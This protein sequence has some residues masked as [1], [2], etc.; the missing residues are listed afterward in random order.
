M[1]QIAANLLL[2]PV[3]L[4]AKASGPPATATGAIAPSGRSDTRRAVALTFDDLPATAVVGGNC[5]DAKL[6]ALNRR[7]LAHL[8]RFEIRA[9]GLVTETR[10]CAEL[11]E[12]VLPRAL[13]L[14]LDDGHDLGNHTYS[15]PDLNATPLDEY[16]RDV[17]RGERIVRRLLE[18]RGR[19]LRG[20]VCGGGRTRDP[21]GSPSAF[22]RAQC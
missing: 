6:I 4:L 20:V 14:W 11:R 5:D 10:V 19:V 22:E 12:G 21:A 3:L 2:L 17:V 16:V 18:E 8:K 1:R 13:A 15:H 9:T 7:L